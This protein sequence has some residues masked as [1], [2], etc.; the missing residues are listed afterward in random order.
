MTTRGIISQCQ[1]AP[2]TWLG[3]IGVN[4]TEILQTLVTWNKFPFLGQ[5]YEVKHSFQILALLCGD[6]LGEAKCS[7]IPV[8]KQL[9]R[10]PQ[11][12]F[13]RAPVILFKSNSVNVTKILCSLKIWNKVTF[14]GKFI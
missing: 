13:K 14:S 8:T 11:T 9:Q 1:D 2:A 5:I 12:K 7:E 6:F 4:V 3:S 10:L